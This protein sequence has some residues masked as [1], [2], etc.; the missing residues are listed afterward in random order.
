MMSVKVERYSHAAFC[1]RSSRGLAEPGAG[2][3]G[4]EYSDR[5]RGTRRSVFSAPRA[6]SV[7]RSDYQYLRQHRE[8]RAHNT[9]ALAFDAI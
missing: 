6:S 3:A 9:D 1:Q 5:I 2:M 7:G 8:V 4:M